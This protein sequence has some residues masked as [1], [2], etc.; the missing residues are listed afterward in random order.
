MGIPER[1]TIISIYQKFLETGPVED[2]IRSGRPSTITDDIINEME[3]PFS[4][5]PQTSVRKI[6]RELNISK[7]KT[8][9]IMHDIIGLKPYMMHCT[10]QL[11]DEDMDLRVEMSEL[12][13]PIF[14]NPENEGNVF[15]SDESSFYVSG[16]VNK[17]NCR[18]WTASN[19]FTTVETAMNSPN[20]N[21]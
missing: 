18:I 12:L 17:H 7:D 20:I 6:G 16:M 3:E 15:F 19:P 13:I 2:R 9:R 21:V 14:E 4:K 10:Q 5:E 8:H 1:H 11:Y